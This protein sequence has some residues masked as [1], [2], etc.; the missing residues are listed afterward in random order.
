[1]PYQLHPDT[2]FRAEDHGILWFHRRTAETLELDTEG[3][4]TLARILEGKRLWRFK[5]WRFFHYLWAKG[6]LQQKKATNPADVLK[7]QTLHQR[8]ENHE[9]PLR[10]RRAPEVLQ[11]SLTDACQQSCSGCFFSNSDPTT[12]NRYMSPTTFERVLNEAVEQGVFQIA[13]GGGEPLMHPRLV[14]YVNRATEAGIVTN[15]TTN[16]A[17]LTQQIAHQLKRA[18]LGQIQFSLNGADATQHERTRP[19]HGEVLKAIATAQA[20]RLRWGINILVTQEH[21]NHH[22]QALHQLL[23]FA[24][25]RGAAMVNLI[26]PKAAQNDAQWL[27]QQQPKAEAHRALQDLLIQ[28]QRK[29]S[30]ALMTDT[31]YTFLRQ[32]SAPQLLAA[33]VGGCS[34]G[35]RMLS[36]QVDGRYSPCSHLPET[37]QEKGTLSQVWHT[38]P[39]LEAFRHLEETLEGECS[40][41]EL[42]SVCRGCRA[43]VLSEGRSFFGEDRQCPKPLSTFSSPS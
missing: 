12:P 23:Q 19:H 28:W 30:F 43:V 36:V 37:M 20:S 14:A 21:L 22:A 3:I 4:Q 42:K 9:S 18:G 29:A 11:I 13:L 31:S 26:R 16:G 15:L 40:T 34:A 35:R 17:L 6:F 5:S 1:M 38:S 2:R 27:D 25:D 8:S 39:H 32:G 24:Q 41:C 10:S 7:V 33:G